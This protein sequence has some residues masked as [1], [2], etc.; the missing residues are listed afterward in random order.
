MILQ[1]EHID[2]LETGNG[3]FN[4]KTLDLFGIKWPPKKGW[5]K[6]IIGKE[7]NEAKY[8]DLLNTKQLK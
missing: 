7:V 6:K 4:K 8:I 2:S 3:G 5:K 1:K